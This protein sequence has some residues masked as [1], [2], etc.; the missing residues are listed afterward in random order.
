LLRSK[1]KVAQL[2]PRR[3]IRKRKG[4]V[5]EKGQKVT[6]RIDKLVE[7][8]RRVGDA[9]EE[10]GADRKVVHED[11]ELE[12]ILVARGGARNHRNGKEREDNSSG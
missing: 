5:R 7:F 12:V 8:R 1:V 9:A 2:L 3:Q 6:P 10:P 11:T 4:N